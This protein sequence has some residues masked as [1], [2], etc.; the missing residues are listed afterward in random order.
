LL[1]EAGGM[2]YKKNNQYT[3]DLLVN[4][5]LF[6]NMLYCRCGIANNTVLCPIR[7]ILPLDLE[8]TRQS[9][10]T[11]IILDKTYTTTN[12][13]MREKQPLLDLFDGNADSNA[14]FIGIISIKYYHE[15]KK[16]FRIWYMFIFENNDET[17]W[18]RQ[19]ILSGVRD[20][21]LLCNYRLRQIN[22]GGLFEKHNI[23]HYELLHYI[24]LSQNSTIPPIYF[25]KSLGVPDNS[26]IF[27]S[28]NA[29]LEENLLLK[30]LQFVKIKIL[31]KYKSVPG[32]VHTIPKTIIEMEY[33]SNI[34]SGGNLDNTIKSKKIKTN[35]ITTLE[36]SKLFQSDNS[37]GKEYN[38][39]LDLYDAVEKI[40]Y[41]NDNIN[42]NYVSTKR[43]YI[44]DYL[45]NT[46]PYI[47]V[48]KRNALFSRQYDY[49]NKY[50][51]KL[52]Y[53][54]KYTPISPLFFTINE[55]TI[56][57]DILKSINEK[58]NI[59][60]IGNSYGFLELIAYKNYKI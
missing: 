54:P 47:N 53:L 16:E 4:W 52:F 31:T 30:D 44:F 14:R 59:M 41:Y 55:L 36:E 22:M 45:L 17:N 43:H 57:Y 32:E 1:F 6:L 11:K 60:S 33:N 42:V 48:D 18:Q 20:K 38:N 7:F 51:S 39:F 19:D 29:N 5:S 9:T 40:A 10:T 2:T 34:Q 50:K 15:E 26:T 35:I 8:I 56:K 49:S 25:Y 21:I 24:S 28:K 27:I 37:I 12:F 13:E 58:S 23:T 46:Y 3:C